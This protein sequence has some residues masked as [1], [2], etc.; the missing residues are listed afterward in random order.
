M[1]VEGRFSESFFCACCDRD[2]P[3]RF[4]APSRLAEPNGLLHRVCKQC[5]DFLSEGLPFLTQRIAERKL[6]LVDP[7]AVGFNTMNGRSASKTQRNDSVSASAEQGASRPRAA[8]AIEK[9]LFHFHSLS[10]ELYI[11]GFIKGLEA[12]GVDRGSMSR[13]AETA[14]NNLLHI[15][16]TLAGER[17]RVQTDACN[18]ADIRRLGRHIDDTSLMVNEYVRAVTEEC[19]EPR[20]AS[21][22]ISS[23]G[24]DPVEQT[25]AAAAK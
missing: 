15:L 3:I 25:G 22:Y 16:Q 11:E 10:V 1:G 20:R 12:A 6:R 8:S 4:L 2:L 21:R 7:E 17:R 14:V 18:R 5:D 24:R 9:D 13:E 23:H 19:L